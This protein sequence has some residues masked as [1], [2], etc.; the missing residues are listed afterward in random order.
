MIGSR[1]EVAE[2]LVGK[3]G[4]TMPRAGALHKHMGI[5][6]ESLLQEPTAS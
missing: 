2:A 1:Q 3:R 4:I 5:P 6:A